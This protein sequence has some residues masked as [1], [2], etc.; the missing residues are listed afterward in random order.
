MILT[1]PNRSAWILDDSEESQ[2]ILVNAKWSRAGS[3]QHRVEIQNYLWQSENPK[4]KKKT[5]KKKI[6]ASSTN[7]NIGLKQ[8]ERHQ[9]NVRVHQETQQLQRRIAVERRQRRARRFHRR[10]STGRQGRPFDR[11]GDDRGRQYPPQH[12]HVLHTVRRRFLAHPSSRHYIHHQHC[13]HFFQLLVAGALARRRCRCKFLS[14][15]YPISNHRISITGPAKLVVNYFGT[16]NS[17]ISIGPNETTTI[18]SI[19]AHPDVHY[20]QT[21]YGMFIIVMI[22]SSILRGLFFVKVTSLLPSLPFEFND[23]YLICFNRRGVERHYI[24]IGLI[25]STELSWTESS[26]WLY[27]SLVDQLEWLNCDGSYVNLCW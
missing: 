10:R 21:V 17:T 22:A 13:Q 18:L 26:Y 1:N 8:E 3:F 6:L 15:Q 16:Q 2:M 4:K 11:G 19:T 25:D 12:V 24:S 7:L 9:R 23:Q 14:H 5:K 27:E 20:Y